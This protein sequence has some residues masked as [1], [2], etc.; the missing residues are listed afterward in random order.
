M[1]QIYQTD[2]ALIQLLQDCNFLGVDI[3][4]GP[5]SFDGSYIQRL[6]SSTPAIRVVFLGCEKYPDS[7]TSLSM[8][9][10]WAIIIITGW[11]GASE[12]ARRI[13]PGAALDLLA[14]AGGALHSAV[15]KDEHGER[16]P[17]IQVDSME[18]L[19]EGSADLANVY[20]AEIGITIEVP[21]EIPEFCQGPLDELIRVRATFDIE[22]GKPRPDIGDAGDAGDSPAQID[23]PQ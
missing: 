7:T 3:A 14:R 22:G 1:T 4:S 20:I 10:K 12:E 8:A 6:L 9:G 15:L 19:S 23:L 11:N 17:L 18:V 5:H 21:L 16:L 13:G 2:S